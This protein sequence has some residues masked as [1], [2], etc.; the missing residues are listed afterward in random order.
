MTTLLRS[1]TGA[2]LLA[3]LAGAVL[4]P[5][6]LSG[7]AAGDPLGPLVAE[8]L[9]NNLGL[10]A[11]RLAERRAAAEVRE[12]RGLFLPSLGLESRYS[13]LDGVPNIGASTARPCEQLAASRRTEK[14]R[15]WRS[16]WIRTLPRSTIPTGSP[17]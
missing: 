1:R 15:N 16:K 4:E 12:A 17:H 6:V 7:Q 9:R 3:L 14:E 2:A 5:T 10:E 11:E 8:A 13:R